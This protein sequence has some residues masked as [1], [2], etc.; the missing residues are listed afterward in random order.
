[1]NLVGGTRLTNFTE[2]QTIFLLQNKKAQ[3]GA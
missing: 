3:L 1:M 2:N